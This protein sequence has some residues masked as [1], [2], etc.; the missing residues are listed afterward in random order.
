MQNFHSGRGNEKNNVTANNEQT[1]LTTGDLAVLANANA[2]NN[3]TEDLVGLELTFDRIK[4]PTDRFTAFEILGGDTD[5][6]SMVREITGVILLHHP[7]Y[8]YYKEKYSGGSNSPNCG[9]F[10]GLN[11]TDDPGRACAYCLQILG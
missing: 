3:A 10:V 2:L 5:D 9:S 7:L 8:A 4:I 6:V 1:N 11:G